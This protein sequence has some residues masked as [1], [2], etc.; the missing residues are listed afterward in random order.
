MKQYK[1]PTID[2]FNALRPIRPMCMSLGEDDL[3][4]GNGEVGDADAAEKRTGI[5]D[6]EELPS[7]SSPF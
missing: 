4:G 1:K 2:M 6:E 5:W 7:Q 3:H